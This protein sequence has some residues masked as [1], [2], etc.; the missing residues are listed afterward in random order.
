MKCCQSKTAN[1]LYTVH[2]CDTQCVFD[3][4]TWCCCCK[5]F[6]FYGAKVYKKEKMQ[7]QRVYMFDVFNKYILD[8]TICGGYY[9]VYI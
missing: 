7:K 3:V 5:K 2:F 4:K 9:I 1:K 6:N 8:I